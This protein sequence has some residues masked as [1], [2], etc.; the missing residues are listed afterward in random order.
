MTYNQDSMEF[1][2]KDVKDQ[3]PTVFGVMIGLRHRF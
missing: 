1:T 2:D 3:D